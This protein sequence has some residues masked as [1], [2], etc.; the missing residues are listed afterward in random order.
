VGESA[1]LMD[2]KEE[3]E[4]KILAPLISKETSH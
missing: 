4:D 1:F 2:E 3:I